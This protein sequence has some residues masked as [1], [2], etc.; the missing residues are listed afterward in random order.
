MDKSWIR[1]Y[2]MSGSI[3]KTLHY[4]EVSPREGSKNDILQKPMGDANVLHRVEDLFLG[5]HNYASL[6]AC[7]FEYFTALN[8]ANALYSLLMF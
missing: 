1:G 6:S 4:F 8:R 7:G 2:D 5:T 3:D